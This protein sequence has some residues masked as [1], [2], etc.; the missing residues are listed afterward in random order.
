MCCS[1]WTSIQPQFMDIR[2]GAA[3]AETTDPGIGGSEP[4]PRIPQPSAAPGTEKPT[5]ADLILS[6]IT[7]ED[8]FINVEKY[9]EADVRR[10][11]LRERCMRAQYVEWWVMD[12]RDA[13]IKLL[14]D[15]RTGNADPND[16]EYIKRHDIVV[17][18]IDEALSWSSKYNA[19]L[20]YQMDHLQ[21]QVE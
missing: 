8:Y 14:H 5:H 9:P 12:R 18:E 6:L 19:L 13:W 16:E 2:I 20:P 21:G 11:F 10:R 7:H 3:M 4:T 17:R 1:I 15:V